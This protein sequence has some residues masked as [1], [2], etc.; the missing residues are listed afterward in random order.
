MARGDPQNAQ[1][2]QKIDEVTPAEFAKIP[3]EFIIATPLLTV[4]EAHKVAALTTLNFIESLNK[5]TVRFKIK[6][7]KTNAVNNS[8]GSDQTVG[9]PTVSQPEGGEETGSI[10]VEVP[11]LAIVKVPCLNFDSLSVSFNYNISQIYTQKDTSGQ[12]AE[13]KAS[14]KGLLSRFVD[15]SLVGSVEHSRTRENVVNRGGSLE[16][17]LH[18]S[19][20]QLPPGL[21]KVLNAI[22]ENIEVPRTP[23]K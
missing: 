11:L 13:F 1:V 18:V 8:T 19:E 20:T 16:I 2:A 23:V 12:R 6:T 3:L 17:K 21:E 5:E 7:A 15:A 14:T 10:E 9:K 4:I 22:V